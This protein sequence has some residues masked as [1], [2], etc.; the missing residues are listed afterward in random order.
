M[1]V[2]FADGCVTVVVSIIR[3]IKNAKLILK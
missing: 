2:I 1:N 3:S